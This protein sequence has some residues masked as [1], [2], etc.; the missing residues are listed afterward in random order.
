MTLISLRL[1]KKI[2]CKFFFY[3]A[4]KA[5]NLTDKT[6]KLLNKISFQFHIS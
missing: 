2:S 4:I 6:N 1:E 3:T 5:Y